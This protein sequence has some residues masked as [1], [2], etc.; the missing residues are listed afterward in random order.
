MTR[1]AG[2][3]VIDVVA[4]LAFVLVG[5]RSHEEGLALDGVA[6]AGAP[7]LIA[8]AAGWIITQAWRHPVA[9]RTGVV[10]WTVTTVAGLLLRRFAFDDG[11]AVSFVIVTALVLGLLLVGWRLAARRAG[12]P[13]DVS[14]GRTASAPRV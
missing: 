3:A 7:F 8:L 13:S 1:A 5:R 14:R 12:R 9:V 4:V 6:S 11:S 2:A 10:V